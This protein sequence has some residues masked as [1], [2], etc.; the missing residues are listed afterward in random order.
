MPRC[1]SDTPVTRVMLLGPPGA[2]KGTQGRRLSGSLGVPHIASGAL[3]R[4]AV[5]VGNSLGMMAKGFIDTGELVPDWLAL[6][7]ILDRLGQPD[8]EHG[9]I[10]DGFPRT[11]PQAE[12]LD[13]RLRAEG[14][15]LERVVELRVPTDQLS[16]RIAGRSRLSGR[17]DDRDEVVA[18]RLRVYLDQSAALADYYRARGVLVPV[19]GVGTVDEVADRIEHRLRC[20]RPGDDK[21]GG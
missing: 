12:A 4:H 19:D 14:R 6:Q 3:L 13:D 9:F 16:D 11:L 17:S 18:N 7:I 2:G 5:D 10:L 8:V 20:S 21:D 1:T 15:A